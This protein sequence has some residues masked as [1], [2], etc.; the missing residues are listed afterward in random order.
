V[1]CWY[2][3]RRRRK[4]RAR[5]W[6]SWVEA[7][8]DR[9]GCLDLGGAARTASLHARAATLRPPATAF[10]CCLSV[11]G[12]CFHMQPNR[13]ESPESCA[14]EGARSRRL[15]LAPLRFRSVEEGSARRRYT[16]IRHARRRARYRPALISAV[17]RRELLAFG[18]LRLWLAF[19][20]ALIALLSLIAMRDTA[21]H[22]VRRRTRTRIRLA[23]AGPHIHAPVGAAL[24]RALLLT[25]RTIIVR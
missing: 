21:A 20:L 12:A 24:C 5:R 15:L 13:H 1:A 6:T 11:P 17:R 2:T 10:A 19:M 23:R 14:Q 3:R 4:S 8:R 25:F 22:H 7:A 16:W 9:A 18:R